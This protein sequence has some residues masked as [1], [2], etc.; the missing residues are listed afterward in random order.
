MILILLED[1]FIAG[2]AIWIFPVLLAV[3]ALM[4]AMVGVDYV[5]RGLRG[6]YREHRLSREAWK[7]SQAKPA[8][9]VTSSRGQRDSQGRFVKAP[10]TP[11]MTVK[12]TDH[13]TAETRHLA[14]LA[15]TRGI[16]VTALPVGTVFASPS[17]HQRYVGNGRIEPTDAP[18]G[19]RIERT[20]TGPQDRTTSPPSK[21]RARDAKGRFIPGYKV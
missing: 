16:D 8:E 9:P 20:R 7:R 3:A 18:L 17:G 11:A 2:I 5:V 4:G 1:L 12:Q 10:A 19:T 21:V 6:W 13:Q 14:H 15:R